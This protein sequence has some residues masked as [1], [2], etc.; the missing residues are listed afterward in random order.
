VNALKPRIW[1]NEHPDLDD[2]V[3]M[4]AVAIDA[5]NLRPGRVLLDPDLKTPGASLDKK[6]P[7]ARNSGA[8]SFLIY[9]YDD[10][11]YKSL[12]LHRNATVWVATQ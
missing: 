2:L 8:V 12:S 1:T 5:A 9:D 10:R 7:S 6:V 3:E 4:P 11:T